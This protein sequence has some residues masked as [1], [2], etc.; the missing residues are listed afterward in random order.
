MTIMNSRDCRRTNYH[1]IQTATVVKEVSWNPRTNEG[2]YH[3]TQNTIEGKELSW[4]QTSVDGISWHLIFDC[5]QR[6]I[7]K[8]KDY[9]RT[10]MKWK[11]HRLTSMKSKEHG[12]VIRKFQLRLWSKDHQD[13]TIPSRSKVRLTIVPTLS[14]SWVY[15]LKLTG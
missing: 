12:M 4:N 8:S 15:R 2:L 3:E 14:T 13:L 1:D 9:R 5:N 7:L 6:R 11:D 10:I